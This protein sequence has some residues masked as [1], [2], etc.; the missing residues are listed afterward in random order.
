MRTVRTLFTY[1]K[2]GNLELVRNSTGQVVRVQ[3]DN[4]GRMSKIIDQARREV[5]I[6]WNETVGKPSVITRP[7]VGSIKIQ[8]NATGE[9]TNVKSE[10]GPVVAA[11]ISTAFNELLE[12]IS[13]ATQQLNL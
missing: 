11:Q 4:R 13:P 5:H 8:Y 12:V 10:G 2:K 3:W 1:D 9:M 6:Q 7:Q